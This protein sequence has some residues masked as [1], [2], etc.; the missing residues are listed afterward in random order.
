MRMTLLTDYK[1]IP[2]IGILF[3]V[4]SCDPNEDGK[5]YP[6][7]L[8][9]ENTSNSDMKILAYDTYDEQYNKYFDEPVLKQ[10][11]IINSKNLGPIINL[12]SYSPRI[13][14]SSYFYNIS[15]DSIIIK[16]NNNTGYISTIKPNENNEYIINDS[17]W[18]NNKNSLL[19]IRSEDVRKEG[20]V[21]VY[22]ITQEDYENAHVLP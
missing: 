18:I 12:K 9:I 6:H 3:F 5:D 21:Y 17:Y 22:I 4:C 13:D 7:K 14:N 8:Q 1:I 19:R 10:S 11:L 16:F 20:D 2:I 15:V